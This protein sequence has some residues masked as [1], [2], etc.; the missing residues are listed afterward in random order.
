MRKLTENMLQNQTIKQGFTL[1]EV[2]VVIAIIGILAS[3]TLLRYP[4]TMSKVRDSRVISAMSQFRMQASILETMNDDY[5]DIK[6]CVVTPGESCACSDPTLD[7]LCA[8]MQENTPQNL[9]IRV[10]DNGQGFCA[11]AY[12]SDYNEYLCSDGAL[13]V[14]KYVISPAGDGRA[15]AADCES[16]ESCACE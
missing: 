2:L 10:N 9:I 6:D 8:D 1:I 7:V 11:V 5:S 3:T 16:N 4:H 13:R 12:L 14:K 15:C